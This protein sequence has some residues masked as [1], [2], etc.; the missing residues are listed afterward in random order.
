MYELSNKNMYRNKTLFFK[1]SNNLI[2]LLITNFVSFY[3][4]ETATQTILLKEIVKKIT[5]IQLEDSQYKTFNEF[6]WNQ[7]TDKINKIFKQ[8]KMFCHIYCTLF[9][10]EQIYG[11]Y[12]IFTHITKK[13]CIIMYNIYVSSNYKRTLW[14]KT[15]FGIKT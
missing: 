1:Q 9:V 6:R 11:V 2:T 5:E 8:V 7:Q 12:K 15:K 14:F 13:A 3:R 4:E 10:Q